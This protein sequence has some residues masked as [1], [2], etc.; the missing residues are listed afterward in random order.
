MPSFQDFALDPRIEQS[1]SALGFEEATP[2]QAATIPV[3]LEGHDVIG[4]ART[5]SGKTAAFGLPLLERVKEAPKGVRALVLAPTRELA[6]QV[7]EALRSYSQAL[8][9]RMVT[10]YGGAP[11]PPQLKALK[12]GV[13]IVVGTPGRVLDHLERG[14]LDLSQVELLVLDEADE[15]LRMGFIEAVETVLENT[16]PDRQI[17]LFSATMPKPIAR[18]AERFLNDPQR[19]QV[20]SE[21]LTVEHISQSWIKAPERHKLNALLRILK[22]EKDRGGTLIFTRTRSRCAEVADH[23]IAAGI[24]ADAIHGDLGQ[25]A[26]ERVLK[27]LRGKTLGTLVATDVAARGLD[28]SHLTHVINLDFPGDAEVYVHRIGRTGR[29]GETGRAILLVTP[30]EQRKLRFLQKAVNNAIEPMEVPSDALVAEAERAQLSR[31]IEKVLKK[32]LP[33]NALQWLDEVLE[34]PE[35]TPEAVAA[36]AVHLLATRQGISIEF[37]SQTAPPKW[38]QKTPKKSSGERG[39]RPDFG[40]VNQVEIFLSI[41]KVAGVRPGDVVGAIA[42]D[43]DLSGNDIGK[44]SVFDHKTFVGLSEENADLLIAEHPVLEIRGKSIRVKKARPRPA[45]KSQGF[46][47]FK[48]KRSGGKRPYSSKKRTPKGSVKGGGGFSAPK[49]RGPK[50]KG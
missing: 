37:S 34:N 6:I 4:Q 14:S 27:R 41:G 35:L 47:T 22:T 26:R 42:N 23:L 30:G 33:E 31:D 16:P 49:R 24:N 15:M 8:K 43:T 28:V 40:S 12:K 7:T 29:A 2:I 45:E 17:A 11:Y 48:Q 44:V 21:A 19:I 39:S 3:L 1:I 13:S 36:A 9:L 5:G 50:K 32:G 25:A 10:I 20:E 38:A 18:V 46:S